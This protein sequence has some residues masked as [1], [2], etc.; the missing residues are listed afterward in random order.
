MIFEAKMLEK[1]FLFQDVVK[2]LF[3]IEDEFY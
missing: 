1:S 2:M 3:F